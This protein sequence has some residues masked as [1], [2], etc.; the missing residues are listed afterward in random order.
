MCVGAHEGQK[1]VSDRLVAG[2]HE[3]PD[4]GDENQTQ[5]PLQ[6]QSAYIACFLIHDYLFCS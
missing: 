1:R 4:M 6:H 3:P 5:C 2:S